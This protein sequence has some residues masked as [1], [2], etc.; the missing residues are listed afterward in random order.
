MSLIN[1]TE[2]KDLLITHVEI[3]GECH[4]GGRINLERFKDEHKKAMRGTDFEDFLDVKI[5]KV[6]CRVHRG[7]WTSLQL[8]STRSIESLQ[9][10]VNELRV[11]IAPYII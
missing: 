7:G 5:G 3:S 11:L 1:A 8:L 10:V 4:L 9:D 6:R 2:F